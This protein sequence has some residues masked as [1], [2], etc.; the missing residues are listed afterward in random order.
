MEVLVLLITE[1]IRMVILQSRRKILSTKIR[2]KTILKAAGAAAAILLRLPG[3]MMMMMMRRM[4]I[5]T[6]P[7]HKRS[8][9]NREKGRHFKK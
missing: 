3:M 5:R 6:R 8:A 9:R 7:I 2:M 4:R 1:S